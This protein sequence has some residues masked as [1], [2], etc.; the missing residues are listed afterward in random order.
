MGTNFEADRAGCSTDHS[1]LVMF[2]AFDRLPVATAE[3]L[4]GY[5]PDPTS[6]ISTKYASVQ[7]Q[8][9]AARGAGASGKQALVGAM[10]TGTL[11]MLD[12]FD[13]DGNGDGSDKLPESSTPD[14]LPEGAGQPAA[15]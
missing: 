13:E 9:A 11:Q 6:K 2:P 4:D 12:V 15:V 8:Y 3:F 10:L 5:T 7:Q 1:Y 14:A